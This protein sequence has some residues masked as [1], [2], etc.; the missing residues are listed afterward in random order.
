MGEMVTIPRAEYELLLAA[1]EDLADLQ[2]YDRA[3][4]Q[5]ASGEEEFIPAASVERILNGESPLRVF[6][7]LRGLTQAALAKASGVGRVMVAEMETGRKQGSVESLR[8]LA[9]A[10]GVSLDDLTR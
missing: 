5:L 7:E 1:R 4:A 9:G 6:R 8:R 2:A 10:L 3:K